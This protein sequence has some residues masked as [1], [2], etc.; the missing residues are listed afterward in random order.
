[1]L[2][3]KE[4]QCGQ[5]IWF[6]GLCF[7][8]YIDYSHA[9]IMFTT[10][11]FIIISNPNDFYMAETLWTQRKLVN[12]FKQNETANQNSQRVWFILTE[13]MLWGQSSVRCVIEVKI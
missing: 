5:Y 13:Y 2:S 9:C 3:R 7:N 8:I 1:M 11:P 6:Y 4:L 10:Y 12:Q